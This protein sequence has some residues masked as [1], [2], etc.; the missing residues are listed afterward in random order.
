MKHTIILSLLLIILL[1]CYEVSGNPADPDQEYHYN[2]NDN[3][4]NRMTLPHGRS[5]R[6]SDVVAARLP[7]VVQ[8]THL[9]SHE[10]TSFNTS[11]LGSYPANKIKLGFSQRKKINPIPSPHSTTSTIP[12]FSL[13]PK[14]YVF[15]SV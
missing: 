9:V 6:G 4:N 15:Q 8:L 1:V 2:N 14:E 3:N 5:K 13:P 10:R 11:D 7:L 12:S